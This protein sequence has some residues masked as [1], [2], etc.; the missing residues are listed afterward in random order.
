M[1]W[2]AVYRAAVVV[3]L[4]LILAQLA[5]FL[6]LRRDLRMAWRTLTTRHLPE[7]LPAPGGGGI[8]AAYEEETIRALQEEASRPPGGFAGDPK[9]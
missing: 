2:V 4:A 1:N 7:E 3:L 5:G 9:K 6:D 8:G